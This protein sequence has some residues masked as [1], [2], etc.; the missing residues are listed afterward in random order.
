MVSILL[1]MSN[2]S[3][4]FS[5]PLGFDPN[6]LSPTGFTVI[7]MFYY[8]FSSLEIFIY[9]S[10][11]S[12]SFILTI[13]FA[14][15]G[16]F[17]RWQV[18]VSSCK[19][20]LG[21]MFPPGVGGPFLPQNIREFYSSHFLGQILVCVY[22]IRQQGQILISCTNLRGLHVPPS[23]ANFCI[24]FLQVFCI[25]LLCEE[26]F[27]LRHTWNIHASGWIITGKIFLERKQRNNV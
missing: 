27:Y 16:K 5:Q 2:S 25:R 9:L 7:L 22:T 8:F 10:I 6:A 23:H 19:F 20:T 12:L 15:T 21:R 24:P 3:K 26:L 18:F 13:W 17:T 4:L 1:L 11:F 14:R